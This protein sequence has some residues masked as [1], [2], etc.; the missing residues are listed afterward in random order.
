M[1][2]ILYLAILLTGFT[3]CKDFLVEEPVLSQSNEL[4][5]SKFSG[6]NDATAGLYN[7]FQSYSW[8]GAQFVL[9]SELSGGN[10]MNPV[11]YPGSGRYRIQAQ[12]AYNPEATVS[13]WHYA[14]YT[15]AA[16]N[17]VINNLEGKES[18]EV[19]V[20]DINNIKAEAL[21]IRA[22]CY[23]DL[24]NVYAQPYTYDKE[25]LGVPVVL[26]TKIGQPARET[27]ATVYSQIE[28]DLTTAETL[29]S[30]SYVRA[31]VV[32]V[33][34]VITKPVIQAL[35]SR[36]YLYM[37]NY[38]KAADYATMV[39]NS[40]KYNLLSGDKYLAMFTQNTAVAGDEIIFEMYSSNKNAYWDGSG[41]EQMSYITSPAENQAGSA[42]VCASSDLVKLFAEGDIRKQLYK[43]MN[44][45][46]WFCLK[47]AGKE[48]SAIPKENNTIIIRLSEMYL[49]RAEAIYNGAVISGITA[50]DDLNKLAEVRGITASSPSQTTI[51]QER[52]K[53][54]AFEGHIFFDLKR[55]GN[56][57][58]RTDNG[59]ES[60]SFPDKRWALP[61]P[62]SE[63]DANPNIVQNEY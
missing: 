42:D 56:G 50:Q 1:K 32:D 63:C 39:I 48:G 60:V 25:Q 58:V 55:T 10:A 4:T 28:S 62:K 2:K 43:Y 21:A 59:G 45:K 53:E 57:V 34:A 30:D 9:F 27:V 23:F 15:I 6:L 44:N 54:L 14:Y 5:L 3:S 33:A 29:M 46:D 22:L 40:G 13:V 11:T 20:Q 8:Y 61:I 24:V 16:A 51:L 36:V 52:R 41:W 37:G 35:L 17:N 47:Y 38:Q 19:T 49:N 26:E 12:W 18:D 7:R 31:G